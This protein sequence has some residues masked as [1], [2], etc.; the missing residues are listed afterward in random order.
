[1]SSTLVDIYQHSFESRA[2]ARPP[3]PAPFTALHTQQT[4]V[5]DMGA[6]TVTIE[7]YKNNRKVA[8]LISRRI[9]GND[10]SDVVIRPGVT[11]LNDYM[12]ALISQPFELPSSILNKRAPHEPPFTS[13]ND[14]MIKMARRAYWI[15][16]L[17]ADAARRVVQRNELLAIQSFFNGEMDIG[18]VFQGNSKL[19]FPRN[20]N[21]KARTVTTSWATAESATPWV[22]YGNAQKA[23]KTYSQLAG[24]LWISMLPSAAMTNLKA[25][26]RK[27]RPL[28]NGPNIQYNDYSF[29]PENTVPPAVA[30]LA[31]N[32]CEY[33]GWI[34]SEY[35][36]SKI[37]LF[38]IPEGYDASLADGTET[39]TDYISGNTV[40]LCMYDPSYFK[41][42]FGPGIKDPPEINLYER[43]FPNTAALPMP[44]A[45]TMGMTGVPAN[46]MMLNIYQLGRNN[47]IGGTIEQ[48]PIYANVQP[49]VVATIATTTTA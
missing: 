21:L 25:I 30:F 36:Q 10:V 38:T 14:P 31:A 34:R 15:M 41:S 29:N 33:Q 37:H 17:A 27:Q 6:D 24:G 45:T 44:N 22:D 49:D 47:G 7:M 4:P 43:V 19:I 5:V 40:A 28:E 23:I 8:P 46:T 26:Y 48:A 3:V 16:E 18:D 39:Y 12:F 2:L 11:G 20:A 32:G 1:M 9:A 13:G 35:S 42:Y